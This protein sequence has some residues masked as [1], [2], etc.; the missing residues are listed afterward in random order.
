[1]AHQRRR[2]REPDVGTYEPLLRADFRCFDE[3]P[4]YGDAAPLSFPVKGVYGTQDD[5][6]TSHQ[7]RDL[8]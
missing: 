6:C 8:E 5:R 4:P 1:M 7:T 2:L 3:Y